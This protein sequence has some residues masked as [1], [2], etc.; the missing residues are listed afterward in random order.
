M[1]RYI[2]HLCN[3][4]IS[5]MAHVKSEPHTKFLLYP[6]HHIVNRLSY[7]PQHHYKRRSA[8]KNI[9][10]AGARHLGLWRGWFE[11]LGGLIAHTLA[12]VL[13]VVNDVRARQT[14][15]NINSAP[16]PPTDKSY[17]RFSCA[18]TECVT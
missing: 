6:S 15:E 14:R 11:I 1:N 16:P 2:P 8:R 17:A 18:R 13:I 12:Y 4:V 10:V 3:I 7:N 9:A 5:L